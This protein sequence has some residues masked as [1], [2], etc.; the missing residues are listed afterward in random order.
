[1]RQRLCKAYITHNI[2]DTVWYYNVKRT[3]FQNRIRLW[4]SL[5]LLGLHVRRK[6]G[7]F[8]PCVEQ[9][10]E[11]L[12]LRLEL[13]PLAPPRSAILAE[14]L[15]LP[16]ERADSGSERVPF[17]RERLQRRALVALRRTRLFGEL[18][19]HRLELLPVRAL[20][21][22]LRR[23]ARHLLPELLRRRRC[24][25]RRC[26]RAPRLLLELRHERPR[27]L[28]LFRERLGLA[29]ARLE[30]RAC[31]LRLLL[32]RLQRLPQPVD[33]LNMPLG[34][35][36]ELLLALSGL[37]PVL[38]PRSLRLA[39]ARE[40]VCLR[41]LERSRRLAQPPLRLRARGASLRGGELRSGGA[42]QR[43]RLSRAGARASLLQLPRRLLQ[44]LV[45]AP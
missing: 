15:V 14:L 30:R 29:L 10:G 43:R 45:I 22:E 37:L 1:M 16:F 6:L 3:N 21:L 38:A 17:R 13:V 44:T 36:H 31:L 41:L 8:R 24:G 39:H 12:H 19:H 42:L 33:L 2:G 27:L 26:I 25:T 23:L 20:A 34:P 4:L 11:P 7:L 35:L 40:T 28:E 9:S 32:A 18:L 5:A